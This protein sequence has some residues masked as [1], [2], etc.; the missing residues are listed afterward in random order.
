MVAEKYFVYVLRNATGKYYIGITEDVA[1]RLEQHNSG[2]S[3]WTSRFKP[4]ELTWWRGPMAV[5]E[6]R[7]LENRLKRQKGGDGFFNMTG[8]RRSS[9][10]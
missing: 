4:W 9:G 1:G 6:A 3:K 8:L 2:C 7:K 5:S 10:S